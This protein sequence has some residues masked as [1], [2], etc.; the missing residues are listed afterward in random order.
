MARPFH[1][2][3]TRQRRNSNLGRFFLRRSIRHTNPQT[4]GLHQSPNHLIPNTP[5]PSE[6][7][8]RYPLFR[9][10]KPP[11]QPRDFAGEWREST[12]YSRLYRFAIW[13]SSSDFEDCG[14][15]K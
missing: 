5:P 4:L 15:G 11:S 8:R 12:L 10:S 9:L 7:P 13:E 1:T 6:I 3:H 14:E 2:T